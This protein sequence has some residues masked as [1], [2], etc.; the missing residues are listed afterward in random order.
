MAII[1][2]VNGI[3]PRIHS[4]V[5]LA[6][7]AVVTGEVS[8]GRD[9]SLWFNAVVRGDVNE[10]TIG[11]KVN[12]QDNA[13]IH[14]TYKKFST[15]IGD[16]V[17]IGHNAV[18]HGCTVEDDVLL[19]MGCMVLDGALI[20]SFTMV[21]AG[22]LVPQGAVLESGHLYMGIPARKIKPLSQ[23]Q[24]EFFIKR[25]ADNYVKYSGWYEG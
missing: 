14:C 4:S 5:F 8:I 12:I 18:V 17:S 24:I 11:E 21:A 6:D 19:G 2:K 15:H 9:S 23:E 16:R 10:I 22:A 7:N 13:T 25:T 1:K 3:L 20:P